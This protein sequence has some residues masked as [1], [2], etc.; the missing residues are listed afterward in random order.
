MNKAIINA[1]EEVVLTYSLVNVMPIILDNGN[2]GPMQQ[3]TI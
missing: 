1:F 2:F 3:P